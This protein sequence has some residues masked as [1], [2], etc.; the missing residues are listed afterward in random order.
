MKARL[1]VS[2]FILYFVFAIIGANLH[3]GVSALSFGNISLV[4][5]TI[6]VF[7]SRSN[8]Q[9]NERQKFLFIPL[10][11]FIVIVS[12]YLLTSLFE[13]VSL[14]VFAKYFYL[15][16]IPVL[17]LIIMKLA[18]TYGEYFF[19]KV[20][21]VLK[22]ILIL[23]FLVVFI[24]VVFNIHMPSY[25]AEREEFRILSLP[26]AFF[27]NSNGL[28]VM[29]LNL[30]I[31]FVFFNEKFGK[32]LEYYL[33]IA[34]TLFIE[35]VTFS[36]M[37]VI[38][39]VAFFP[40]YFILV[41][42]KT[43]RYILI[44]I[45]GSGITIYA[46]TNLVNAYVPNKNLDIAGWVNNR[47]LSLIDE[48]TYDKNSVNSFAIRYEIYSY[49]F[50]NPNEFILGHGLLGD[51][52]VL[53]KV[54]RWSGI[55]NAHSFFIEIIYDFGWFG[56][57]AILLFFLNIFIFLSRYSYSDDFRFGLIITGI[58][59]LLI[60]VSSSIFGKPILWA[61]LF[62][63]LAFLSNSQIVETNHKNV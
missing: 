51:E 53:K 32:R 16:S 54:V 20:Y 30:F 60:N 29:T 24:E 55:T 63:L 7:L 18:N 15:G 10:F 38:S 12:F 11:I 2:G 26:T 39:F 48:K 19:R 1:I 35:I 23:L 36:R 27:E 41:R 14:R 4:L 17:Y 52:K 44:I 22:I 62:V 6:A 45:I 43:V 34:I 46:L 50:S 57:I 21:F 3:V 31:L 47:L 37:A 33:F 58:F 5:L 13:E 8:N 9:I 59:M 61:P 40:L 25:S 56:F 42:H 49:P 28:G